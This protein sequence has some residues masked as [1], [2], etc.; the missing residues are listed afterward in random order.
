MIISAEIAEITVKILSLQSYFYISCNTFKPTH[1]MDCSDIISIFISNVFAFVKIMEFNPILT[2][3]C[4]SSM[5]TFLT[6][7][8]FFSFVI[9]L[10]HKYL[11]HVDRISILKCQYDFQSENEDLICFSTKHRKFSV[12]CVFR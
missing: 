9:C 1:Y 5:S 4:N 3:S 10:A 11:Y 6:N 7:N 8:L 2:F 12:N